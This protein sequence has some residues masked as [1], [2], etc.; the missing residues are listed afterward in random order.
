MTLWKR[1][2]GETELPITFYYTNDEERVKPVE[3]DSVPRCMILAISS[4][5]NGKPLCLC[6]ESIHCFG[7]KRFTGFSQKLSPDFEYFLSCGIP[8]KLKGERYKKSPDL[9]K[10]SLKHVPSFKA[11]AKFIVF[12]R[13]DTLEESDNP[14]V[15]IFFA[16]P[17][18]LSG[19]CTLASFDEAEPNS[20][21]APFGSGCSSIVLY[22]YV[23]KESDHPK[24]VIGLF[25]PS[26]R[27]HV[28]RNAITFS[29]PMAR[30]SR[31][32]DNMEES[33][34]A[35]ET[36]GKVLKRIQL[37]EKRETHK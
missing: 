26:A 7:G 22:P 37:H 11:P 20:V 5:R 24:A 23:E 27:P 19:L 3:P 8:G 16:E 17:D 4:V 14:Q 31:M 28:P 2:F 15:A 33:F 18:V 32:I 1:Y 35:T 29:V 34:L 13:W 36:W 21:I 6:A 10:E 9:V 25:D 30:F 12:K